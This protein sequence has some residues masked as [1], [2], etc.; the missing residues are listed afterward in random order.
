MS[1]AA[2]YTGE[3]K[4]NVR[5]RSD[6]LRRDFRHACLRT[7]SAGVQLIETQE[8]ISSATKDEQLSALRKHLEA[9]ESWLDSVPT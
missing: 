6:A 1:S 7:F 5:P 4:I 2:S 9:L 3:V 8:D